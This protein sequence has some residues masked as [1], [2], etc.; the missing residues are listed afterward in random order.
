MKYFFF[1]SFL[2]FTISLPCHSQIKIGLKAG[3]SIV[4]IQEIVSFPELG[5][6]TSNGQARLAYQV[7]SFISFPWKK[8]FSFRLEA[9]ISNKGEQ[10]PISNINDQPAQLDLFYINLPVLIDFKASPNFSFQ[11]GPELGYLIFAKT[12]IG[13]PT[14]DLTR[15]LRRWDMGLSGGSKFALTQK[16]SLG[17]RYSQGFITVNPGGFLANVR[18]NGIGRLLQ[19]NQAVQLSLNYCIQS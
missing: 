15:L 16:L 17:L 3:P 10:I 9:L 8:K 18:F 7:G 12:T 11:L 14:G 19:W 13:S 4:N 1:L 6:Y 5:E 2:L